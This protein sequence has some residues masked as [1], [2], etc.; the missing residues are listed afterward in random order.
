[1]QPDSGA[2]GTPTPERPGLLRHLRNCAGVMLVE[3]IVAI[4]ALSLVIVGASQ[5]LLVA[6][7]MAAASRVLTA[8]RSVVQR[9]IDTAL[10]TTFTQASTP[11][12]L[13]ITPA[14]GTVYDDDGGADN[15]VQISVQDNNTAIVAS[16]VLTRT[17]TQL[18]NADNAV[19]LQVT[20]SL[21]W[22]YRGR[23]DTISMTTIRARD[24]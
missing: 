21:T 12:I 14:T 19:V 7:R 5:A 22:T 18:A 6:N 9:N 16:G 2:T 4:G 20:F 10:T 11:A 17:V 8:A 3:A 24:D 15:T 13:A 1:M 23:I